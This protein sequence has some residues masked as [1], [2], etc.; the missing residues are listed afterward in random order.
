MLAKQLGISFDGQEAHKK[1]VCAD[2]DGECIRTFM[3]CTVHVKWS[4]SLC[5]AIPGHCCT[6][7]YFKA[8]AVLELLC[9]ST[10]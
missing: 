10:H 9:F 2:A 4:L 6:E 7:M 5:L 8:E 3:D 1:L